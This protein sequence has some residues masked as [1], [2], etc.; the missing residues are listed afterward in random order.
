MCSY[1]A[2]DPTIKGSS[3]YFGG[4]V[5]QYLGN[6]AALQLVVWHSFETKASSE[7]PGN[8]HSGRPTADSPCFINPTAVN[9]TAEE[10]SS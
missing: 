7:P 1:L 10:D 3:R 9:S 4:C 6:L 5:E 8:G 2:P